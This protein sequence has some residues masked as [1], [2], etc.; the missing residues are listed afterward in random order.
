MCNFLLSAS[1]KNENFPS[2][3]IFLS[4]SA[5][6]NKNLYLFRPTKFTRPTFTTSVKD[7]IGLGAMLFQ[8]RRLFSN[9]NRHFK[10]HH[11]SK[12]MHWIQTFF[13]CLFL[14]TTKNVATGSPALTATGIFGRRVPI[15]ISINPAA[16]YPQV[17]RAGNVWTYKTR[18]PVSRM[19]PTIR[20]TI[21]SKLNAPDGSN[22]F[23]FRISASF[24]DLN[25]SG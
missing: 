25:S 8:I 19:W 3:D 23:C 22:I 12:N 21:V 5:V 14:Q 18:F 10:S 7:Q 9:M 17:S 24:A 11:P 2:K 20:S 13:F 15:P 1:F 4:Y 16:G 6:F